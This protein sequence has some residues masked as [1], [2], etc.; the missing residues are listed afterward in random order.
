MKRILF[1]LAFLIGSFSVMQA[2]EITWFKATSFSY[3]YINDYGNWT[4]WSAWEKC[5]VK[6]KFELDEDWIIIYSNKTQVYKV[7]ELMD[8]PYDANGTSIKFRTIDGD[9]DYGTIRLRI[10]NNGNSQLYCDFQNV[11][12]VYN[13]VRINN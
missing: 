4:N 3:R 9:G 8:P 10:E 12:W 5:D 2:Q 7:L 1:I 6:V 11:M 13:V